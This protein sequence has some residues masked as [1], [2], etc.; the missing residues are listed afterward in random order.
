MNENAHNSDNYTACT[1]DNVHALHYSTLIN[2]SMHVYY[3][4]VH[5]T[6]TVPYI[7]S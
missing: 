4:H 5:V 7:L 1:I 2:T 6:D 3:I